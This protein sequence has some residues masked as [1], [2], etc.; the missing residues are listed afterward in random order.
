MQLQKR[1][2]I[3]N[4]KYGKFHKNLEILT[5]KLI[6]LIKQFET[7][8]QKLEAKPTNSELNE[9]L[10]TTNNDFAINF[11]KFK[12]LI[13]E[14]ITNLHGSF[15]GSA[16][17]ILQMP[18]I[19]DNKPDA[20]YEHVIEKLTELLEEGRPSQKNIYGTIGELVS[21]IILGILSFFISDIEE[22]D[23]ETKKEIAKGLRNHL[24][25]HEKSNNMFYQIKLL[26]NKDYLL[27]Y[28]ALTQELAQKF[29]ISINLQNEKAQIPSEAYFFPSPLKFRLTPG[30][31]SSSEEKK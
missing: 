15:D 31:S 24:Q 8:H 1:I 23:E 29:N 14:I 7:L 25:K 26:I 5:T 27:K 19:N 21:N 22:L 6:K 10:V 11:I 17:A 16:A 9:Q 4:A 28:T 20:Y 13:E 3:E 30:S 18:I 2:R 12:Q